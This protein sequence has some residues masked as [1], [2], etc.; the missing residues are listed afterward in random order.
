MPTTSPVLQDSG[1]LGR[2]DQQ[3]GHPG[4]AQQ[5]PHAPQGPQPLLPHHGGDCGTGGSPN[6]HPGGQHSPRG[7]DILQSVGNAKVHPAD[8]AGR[9][10]E[11]LRPPGED[12]LRLQKLDH[13]RGDNSA[14][15]DTDSTKLLQR[16]RGRKRGGFEAVGGWWWSRTTFGRGRETF[17]T[18]GSLDQGKPKKVS[19]E[20]HCKKHFGGIPKVFGKQSEFA[21]ET[22]PL[23]DAWTNM[24]RG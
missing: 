8:E 21:E 11:G 16:G 20:V 23:V 5:V 15:H 4:S 19:A 24:G 22:V 12:R 14:R 9:V 6:N 10:G 2:H 7:D 18:D 17:E 1:H 13:L 3:A